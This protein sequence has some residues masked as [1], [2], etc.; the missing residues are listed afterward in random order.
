VSSIKGE[1]SSKGE[2][3]S[4][5]RGRGGR[6]GVVRVVQQD[7]WLRS[8][9]RRKELGRWVGGVRSICANSE[10]EQRNES[11]R[12]AQSLYSAEIKQVARARP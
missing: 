4:A 3:G 7:I 2:R 1:S 10:M 11:E 9:A 6:G 5:S 12:Y 8:E